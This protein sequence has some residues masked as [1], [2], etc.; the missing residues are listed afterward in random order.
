MALAAEPWSIELNAKVTW[1]LLAPRA[2]AVRWQEPVRHEC[3]PWL[4]FRASLSCSVSR[5]G[6][7]AREGPRPPSLGT[8]TI[9]IR[10][11]GG[12]MSNHR[13]V[14]AVIAAALLA[15]SIMAMGGCA[16]KPTRTTTKTATSTTE[17]AKS[18][19]TTPAAP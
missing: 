6:H 5:K 7:T 16:N 19:S 3:A 14:L 11:Q 4:A 17:P 8:V 18:T 1:K 13:R 10:R 2:V 15:A 9:D 12:W